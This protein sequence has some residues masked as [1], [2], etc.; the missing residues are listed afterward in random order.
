MKRS[1]KFRQSLN[2]LLSWI[3][4][5]ISVD[6]KAQGTVKARLGHLILPFPLSQSTLLSPGLWP[7]KM[8]SNVLL[9]KCWYYIS[10]FSLFLKNFYLFYLFIFG[11]IGSLLL[12]AGFVWLRRVGA[13]LR[14]GARASHCGGFSCCGARA[15]GSCG[16]SSCGLRALDRRLS[17]CGARA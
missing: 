4:T 1:Q 3:W 11:C 5:K 17:S 7:D 15:L 6:I 8:H 10:V 16:L 14:C 9:K 2:P 13:T 12:C